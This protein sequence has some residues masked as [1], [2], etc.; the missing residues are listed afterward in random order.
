M[1]RKE[2]E[3]TLNEEKR[4]TFFAFGDPFFNSNLD[5]VIIAFFLLA[6]S[7]FQN[8]VTALLNAFVC[9]VSCLIC[10]YFSFRF[11]LK[12]EKPLSDLD[13]LKIGLFTALL[14]P[15]CVPLY[16]SASAGAFAILV[17]KLP[18]GSA[19]NAP[20]VPSAAA[21]CFSSLCFPQYVF[22]YSAAP[23]LQKI[24]F[25]SSAD[26]VKGTSLL[27]LLEKGNGIRPNV[28]SVTSLLS[29]AYPG[30][31]GTACVLAL[32]AAAIYLLIRRSKSLFSSGGFVLSCTVFAFLFPRVESGRMISVLCELCAGS[33]LFSALLLINDSPSVPKKGVYAFLFGAAAGI[34][35][36]L[37]RIFLKDVDSGCLSVMIANALVLIFENRKKAK[38]FNE[39]KRRAS[40]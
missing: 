37:I 33:L 9:V 11:I 32:L 19:K 2:G 16:V 1:P 21:V 26:F 38:P 4:K 8:G 30:A 29:G 34:F 3:I 24:A 22:S 17:C 5:A 12:K 10:E 28:F 35:C 31:S 20:F 40:V 14:L 7:F 6:A 25:S 18:F 13:A 36:M 27:E 39:K 15:S 23:E